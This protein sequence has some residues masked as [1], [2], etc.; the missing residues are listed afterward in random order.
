MTANNDQEF[1]NTNG[2]G[3]TNGR[4]RGEAPIDT[5]SVNSNLSDEEIDIK[6][7]VAILLHNKWIIISIT[8]VVAIIAAV[9]SVMMT[10]IYE[11]Q[12]TII[13][14][15]APNRY[16]MAGNDLSNLLMSSYGI[17][18]GSS[19]QSE[20][21]VLNS[22]T[23]AYNLAE[24]IHNERVDVNG[25]LYPLLWRAYPKDSSLTT[26]DTVAYR[27]ML[28][29]IV[30]PKGGRGNIILVSFKSP[31]NYEAFR[32]V[33]L[34]IDTYSDVS[35][36][37]NRV[38]AKAALDFLSTELQNVKDEVVSQE[39]HLRNFMNEQRLVQIDG[40]TSELIKSIALIE[41]EKKA[42]LVNLASINKSID[43]YTQKL[44][45]F[46]PGIAEKFSLALG[47][48]LQRLQVQLAEVETERVLIYARNPELKQN[49]EKNKRLMDLNSQIEVL[50]NEISSSV[51]KLQENGN[52]D[53]IGFL[54]NPDGGV[55]TKIGAI[56][57]SLLKLQIEK[58]QTESKLSV[59]EKQLDEH[60]VVFNN[61]PNN[62]IEF[63]R[64]KRDLQVNEQLYLTL[65]RQS[66]EMALWEQT[67]SG[68]ARVV[69]YA[70]LPGKPV[71]PKKKIIVI[72]ATFLGL[73]IS[74]AIV[75]VKEISKKEIDSV[76]K[77]KKKLYP[78][79]AVIPNLQEYIDQHFEGKETIDIGDKRISTGLV[80]LLDSISPSAEAYRR[81]QSNISYSKPDDPYKVILVTSSNKSEG[82]TTLSANLAVTMAETGNRV[83]L[84]DCDFRR[85]RVH[86]VWGVET[87]PGLVDLLFEDVDPHKFIKPSVVENVFV[88]TA[89]NRPPNPAEINRSK[90][91]RNLIAKLR[92]EFDYV[93][94]D[95]PPYGIITDAAPLVKLADGV[96]LVCKFNQT[97][98]AEF[99]NTIESLK[100]INANVIGTVMT[101]FD[102]KK[103]SGYYY[104]DSYYQYSYQSY[105]EYEKRDTN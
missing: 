75:F 85:P 36:R 87:S 3:Y 12:G 30:E 51:M 20:L 78:L 94:L 89:G 88:L 26:V 77:L 41:S 40:Q 101:A 93:I 32:I 23:M 73:F 79:L 52:T 49:P 7:V 28:N 35:T 64:M 31:S 56:Q 34:I 4:Y 60:E 45:D 46:N 16:S 19:I 2:A 104:T 62:M 86:S 68:L 100:R 74:I 24:R 14:S 47:P 83:L 11:S 6:Q 18:I 103:S 81:L 82:K 76:E 84:I 61:L 39:E 22:R 95:T 71:E 99:D 43:L 44:D 5:L 48:L 90:K 97:R 38:Q 72:I 58:T 1:L 53:F 37:T 63:A 25:R 96:V 66:S 80:T 13:I 9:A 105:K 102:A 92:Y 50:K 59:L 70:F 91:L 8:A 55:S 33:N 98:N 15:E 42:L 57:E 17:G 29:K 21:E 69:D 54:G 10:P 67:Q 27:I 65:A